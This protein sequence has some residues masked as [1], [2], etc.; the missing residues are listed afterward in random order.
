MQGPFAL[1][2]RSLELAFLKV[3]RPRPALIEGHEL[4]GWARGRKGIPL[5]ILRKWFF[6]WIFSSKLSVPEG[7]EFCNFGAA[8]CF[9]GSKLGAGLFKGSRAEARISRG[10][11]G[12]SL[13]TLRKWF[14]RWIFN[15]KLSVPEG[16]EFCNFGAAACF[17]DPKL[18]A[19]FF[20]GSQAEARINRGPRINRVG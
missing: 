3:L 16:L 5:E 6:R 18:G 20:T 8:A 4:I 15:S 19:S 2:T 1:E 10:R 9:G 14:C 17:G 12:I 11:K 7:L 13:E